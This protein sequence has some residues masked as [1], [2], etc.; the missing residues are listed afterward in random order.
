MRMTYINL[1]VNEHTLCGFNTD[2]VDA[3]SL[4]IMVWSIITLQ[5]FTTFY[6]K[7]GDITII[8]DRSYKTECWVMI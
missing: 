3:V 1:L 7:E 4:N 6:M 8:N 5:N 2:I